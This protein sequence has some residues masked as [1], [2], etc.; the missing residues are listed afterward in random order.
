MTDFDRQQEFH[1]SGDASF[2]LADYHFNETKIGIIHEYRPLKEAGKGV[3]Y[4]L[5]PLNGM[6]ISIGDWTPYQDMERRYQLDLKMI[7]IYYFESG[8]VTLIQNGKRTTTIRKGINLYL[9]RPS[10]GRVHY[11]AGI[12]IRYV[13]VLLLEDYFSSFL[14]ERFTSDDFDYDELFSWREFDY[15]TP[16][17]GRIFLQIKHKILSEETSRLYYESKVGELL[18]IV[19]GN[20]HRQR[21]QLEQIYNSLSPDEQKSLTKVRLAIEQNI[22]NPPTSEELCRIAAMGG[23]KLRQTFRLLYGVSPR[24]YIVN[25]KMRYA[26]LL[27]S[28]Q[29]PSIAAIASQLGYA[30]ASKF[31]IAFRKTYQQS[32]KEYRAAV[33]DK[34]HNFIT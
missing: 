16:E 12:P 24:E 27:L 13:S 26:Q 34:S 14:Q 18:S 4:Q 15:N 33:Q 30:S 3:V 9:N 21:E 17:I 28:K 7:K 10:K 11:Q 31:S 22:L 5:Q 6:F 19:G 1:D 20:F 8:Y 29:T 2:Y 25:T 32:P 23:T